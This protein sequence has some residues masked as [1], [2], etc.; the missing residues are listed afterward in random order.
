[1]KKVG[2]LFS[3]VCLIAL[4][5]SMRADDIK[6]L[7]GPA[8]HENGPFTLELN[9]TTTV[10]T[11]CLDVYDRTVYVGERW[12]ADAKTGDQFYTTDK[13]STDFKYMEET[14]ILSMLGQSNG[15]GGVFDNTDVQYALWDIFDPLHTPYLTDGA[16]TLLQNAPNFNYTTAF[17]DDYTFYLPTSWQSNQDKPQDM[18]GLTPAPVPEPSSLLLLGTGLVGALGAV[19]RKV[20]THTS[21]LLNLT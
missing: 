19:R 8:A 3:T 5:S 17:L 20:V 6:L 13:S 1:M 21:R 14:Y 15:Q 16:R 7:N 10:Q 4:S 12:T 9:G 18:L 11:W 2:F